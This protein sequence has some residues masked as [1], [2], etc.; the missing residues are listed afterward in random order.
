MSDET[1]EMTYEVEHICE[2]CGLSYS[3]RIQNQKIVNSKI[4]IVCDECYEK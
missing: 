4:L 2:Q 3:G 1:I